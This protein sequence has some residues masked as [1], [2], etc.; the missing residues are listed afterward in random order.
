MLTLAGL[1]FL[2]RSRYAQL[3]HIV[4]PG[5]PKSGWM[6][7]AQGYFVASLFFALA[8]YSMILSEQ[9]RRKMMQYHSLFRPLA[10]NQ[11]MKPTAPLRNN[12]SVFATTP[13]VGLSLSR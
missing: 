7:P 9:Q 6:T 8:V 4:I 3:H 1:L 5:S 2:V 13:S 12:F 11:S 10:S